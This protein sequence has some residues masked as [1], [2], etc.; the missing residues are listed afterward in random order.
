MTETQKKLIKDF[1][2]IS[3]LINDIEEPNK[4]PTKE[5]KA[6]YDILK[7]AVEPME[8]IID[9]VYGNSKGIRNTTF[10]QDLEKKFDYNIE[11]EV[12]RY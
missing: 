4:V 8:K 2:L 7:Q 12:K 9:K 11:R 6:V 1:V 5:I 10:I 3:I